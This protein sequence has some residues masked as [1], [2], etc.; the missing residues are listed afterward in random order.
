MLSENIDIT[1][2][3]GELRI[4]GANLMRGC[5]QNEKVAHEALLPDGWLGTGDIAYI[6]ENGK[7]FIVD[8]KKASLPTAKKQLSRTNGHDKLGTH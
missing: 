1:N 6:N 3:R 5:W 2:E 8:R 7:R 4:H